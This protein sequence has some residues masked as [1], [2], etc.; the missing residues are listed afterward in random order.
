MCVLIRK[1]VISS[2]YSYLILYKDQSY[3]F[4]GQD[5]LLL[6]GDMNMLLSFLQPYSKLHVIMFGSNGRRVVV[7]QVNYF[8]HTIYTFSWHY[9]NDRDNF[10]GSF[11]PPEDQFMINNNCHSTT[12]N[13]LHT[14]YPQYFVRKYI[15]AVI[16]AALYLKHVWV[17]QPIVMPTTG[18]HWEDA[19]ITR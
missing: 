3:R 4:R 18:Q 13:V 7:S 11:L 9:W 5:L 15:S 1:E 10:F 17:G 14:K 19:V 8:T 12:R 6:D 2:I 16:T